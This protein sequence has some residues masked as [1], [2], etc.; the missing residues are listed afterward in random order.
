MRGAVNDAR[1]QCVRHG[2]T[3]PPP[4]SGK[5]VIGADYPWDERSMAMA[6]VNW[7]HAGFGLPPV[8]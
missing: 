8:E 6:A 2:G 5:S 1:E 7:I 4:T 3:D